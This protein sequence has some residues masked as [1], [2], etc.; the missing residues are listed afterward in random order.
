MGAT[1]G[2]GERGVC[3]G[4]RGELGVG[5]LRGGARSGAE[6]LQGGGAGDRGGGGWGVRRDE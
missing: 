4:S 6:G 5:V 2:S 3:R 1:R